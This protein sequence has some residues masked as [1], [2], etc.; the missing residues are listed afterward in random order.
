MDKLTPQ[1]TDTQIRQNIDALLKQGLD[2]NKVQEYVNNYQKNN[3]GTFIL[4]S[5]VSNTQPQTSQEQPKDLLTKATDVVTSIFPGKQVGEAIGT[6]GGALYTKAKDIITGSNIYPDYDLSA[7]KPLQVAGDIVSG[8]STIAG[9][10]LPVPASLLGAVGQYG[11]LG[12]MGTGGESL[13]KGNTAEQATKEAT[14]GGIIG[15]ITGGIFNLLGKGINKL[16]SKTGS[17]TLSFTSGVP[18]GAI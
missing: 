8:A 17:S 3:D 1:L 5:S 18:K 16:A 11:A 2:K 9:L 15:A 12:A 13:A 14:K 6:A 4:K 10:K 7:P